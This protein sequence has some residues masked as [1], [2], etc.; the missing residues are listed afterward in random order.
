[1]DRLKRRVSHI[2]V[3]LAISK[4]RAFAV[5]LS[6]VTQ[7]VDI[8]HFANSTDGRTVRPLIFASF[9]IIISKKLRR[10]VIWSESQFVAAPSDSLHRWKRFPVRVRQ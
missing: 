5:S 8:N 2:A 7:H 1:M 6:S 9:E 10:R 3:S 4:D